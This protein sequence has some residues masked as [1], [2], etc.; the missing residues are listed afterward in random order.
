[1]RK[2]KPHKRRFQVWVSLPER[3]YY[4]VQAEAQRRFTTMAAVVREVL[5]KEFLY[6]DDRRAQSERTEDA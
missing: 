6:G 1:M 3:L 2:R 4:A 5:A